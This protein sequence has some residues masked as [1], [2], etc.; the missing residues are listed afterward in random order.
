MRTCG[1]QCI[2]ALQASMGLELYRPGVQDGPPQG[3]GGEEQALEWGGFSATA[4]GVIITVQPGE[5]GGAVDRAAAEA[6]ASGAA[7]GH[8]GRPNAHGT[9]DA[10]TDN[11]PHAKRPRPP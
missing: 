1:R 11:T 4:A 9:D 10:F 5:G 7:G 6:T 8:V 2:Q 3:G